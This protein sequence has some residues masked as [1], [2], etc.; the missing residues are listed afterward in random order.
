MLTRDRGQDTLV[1]EER[2]KRYRR[3]SRAA[4]AEKE[5]IVYT[6]ELTADELRLVRAALTSYLDELGRE[7]GA[8]IEEIR[9]L[10]AKL[11]IMTSAT[12]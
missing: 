3:K 4:F 10:M 7:E 5:V 11:P 12:V 1:A 9:K 2:D 6:I 8:I